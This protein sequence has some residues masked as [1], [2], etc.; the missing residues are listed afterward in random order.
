MRK[1]EN[2]VPHLYERSERYYFRRIV[3]TELQPLMQR[4]EWHYSI[5][6]K[7]TFSIEDAKT[8]ALELTHTSNRT[9]Q[10]V[11]DAIAQIDEI[12]QRIRS[13]S[14]QF[15]NPLGFET[16][17]LVQGN[18]CLSAAY[19]YTTQAH[20]VVSEKHRELATRHFI[21]IMGDRDLTRLKRREV[22]EF[23]ALYKLEGYAAG[24]LRRRI[25]A[26]AAIVG[27]FYRD[28]DI[29][30]TNPF[31]DATAIAGQPHSADDKHPLSNMQV[32]TLIQ[33]LKAENSIPDFQKAVLWLIITTGAGPSEAGGLT[34][35]DIALDRDYPHIWIRQNNLR[36]LKARCRERRLPL[37]GEA[38]RLAPHLLQRTSKPSSLGTS[39]NKLLKRALEL[40]HKQSLYSI[41]HW[42]ADQLRYVGASDIEARYVLGHSRTSPHERYGSKHLSLDRLEE[43]LNMAMLG[44]KVAPRS[45]K[46]K[47]LY[48]LLKPGREKTAPS[49]PT[50]NG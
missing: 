16:E 4:R 44:A 11:R 39:L 10:F 12:E 24:T 46:I 7:R 22:V 20:P 21:R 14:K 8:K 19:T 30:R 13:C 43:L 27:H 6:S 26:L 50:D 48:P 36:N 9:I 2:S 32:Q 25:G 31:L 45:C 41:R 17:T 35:S 23:I 15:P 1:L 33:F 3:P 42:M 5:G 34:D 37:I 18:Q 38:R 28:H 49:A 40:T 47:K 29:Q